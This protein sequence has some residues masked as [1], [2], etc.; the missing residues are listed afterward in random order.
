MLETYREWFI[1]PN[2]AP[3]H[4]AQKEGYTAW[5]WGP[6]WQN[7]MQLDAGIGFVAAVLEILARP[8]A[9]PEAWR[10]VMF[11]GLKMPGGSTLAGHRERGEW[12]RLES[13]PSETLNG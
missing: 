4:N 9:V 7:I 5:T 2:Y 3:R 13:A 12:V 1:G 10:D 11:K 8:Q 6:E